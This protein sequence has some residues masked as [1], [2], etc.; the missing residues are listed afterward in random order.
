MLC[1]ICNVPK[2]FLKGNTLHFNEH[3]GKKKKDVFLDVPVAFALNVHRFKKKK[4]GST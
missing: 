2:I 1:L 4:K 3:L